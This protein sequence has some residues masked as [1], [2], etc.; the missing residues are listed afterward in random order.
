MAKFPRFEKCYAAH[1]R[2]TA[3]DDRVLEK[4]N[5]CNLKTMRPFPIRNVSANV[6]IVTPKFF[7]YNRGIDG[8][9]VIIRTPRNK[10]SQMSISCHKP[11]A[12]NA[13]PIV[14]VR[15]RMQTS[16]ANFAYVPSSAKPYKQ[17]HSKKFPII[18]TATYT[19]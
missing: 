9:P 18:S 10:T 5:I 7:G 16:K 1:R 4:K 19:I 6:P 17:P 11:T 14:T 3:A 13:I 8:N 15:D 12:L 2:R